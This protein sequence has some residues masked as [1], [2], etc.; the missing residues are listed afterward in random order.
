MRT[1]RGVLTGCLFVLSAPTALAQA[2]WPSKPLRFVIPANPGTSSEIILRIVYDPIAKA[3]GTSTLYEPKIGLAGTLAL[4]EVAKS[5]PDGHTFGI[6]SLGSLG[7]GPTVYERTRTFDPLKDL[8]GIARLV[9]TSNTLVVNN[10][11]P[12]RS[13]RELIEY[14]KSNPGK[15]NFGVASGYGTS[16]HMTWELFKLQTGVNLVSV[17][18]KGF[19]DA[20]QALLSGN[21]QV[22]M[23]NTNTLLAPIKAGSIRALA[24]TSAKR[25]PVLA[26]VP[27]MAEAGVSGLEVESW[28][29]LVARAGTPRPIIE[30]LA[31]ETL[32]MLDR[33][34]TVAA[35]AKLGFDPYPQGTEY[36]SFY[37]AEIARWAKVIKA[38]GFKAE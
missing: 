11:L 7:I 12:V 32:R 20:L 4:A 17:P 23:S 24:V 19:E 3:L 18:F 29:G 30:R 22:S 34:E 37:R 10:N 31:A 13:V 6:S 1:L 5:A 38:S 2:D 33:P 36:D 27:T 16:F 35:L 9:G 21:V 15:L 25:T 8:V 28:F 14:A 26:D